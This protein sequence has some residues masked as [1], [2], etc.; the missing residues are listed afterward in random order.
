MRSVSNKK[1]FGVSDTRADDDSFII[2]DV[3][4]DRSGVS[5]VTILELKGVSLTTASWMFTAFPSRSVVLA[6]VAK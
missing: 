5:R 1:S 2:R 3:I 6:A 4:H